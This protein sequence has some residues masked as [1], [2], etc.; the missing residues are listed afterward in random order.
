MLVDA[1]RSMLM[2]SRNERDTT[3]SKL[4]YAQYLTTA[5]SHVIT[6]GRDQ[7]GLGIASSGL[8]EYL[9][10]A[11]TPTHATL[12]QEAIEQITTEP[13]TRLVDALEDLFGRNSRRGVLLL[14][15]DFLVDDLEALF[16]K[17]RLYR[18]RQ[19]EVVC[20]H[21]V[22]PD[23]E[24]LPE[25]GAFRFEG[26]ENDGQVACSPAE[27]RAAY[28]ERFEIHLNAVRTFALATGCDYRL[29]STAVPY[30]TTLGGFLVECAGKGNSDN[31]SFLSPFTF[32]LAIG[33]AA[34][35]VAV[36]FLTRPRPVRLPLST[37]RFVQEAVKQRRTRNRLRDALI[38]ALAR[39]PSCCWAGR[40]PGR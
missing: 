34:V 7:V 23:E 9:A 40:L 26:L 13:E 27:I 28:Q 4:E 25:G 8:R 1:S 38:L 36:H 2:G 22:H 17:I 10:P 3:G 16:A 21:L 30:L 39:W 11:S 32:W 20:L 14:A 29:V 5:L 33:A 24:R 18:H 15:T 12:L 31:M 19:W 35:P 6:C 37:I